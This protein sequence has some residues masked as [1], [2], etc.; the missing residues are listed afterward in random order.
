MVF[1]INIGT[2]EG[3]TYKLESE[4][5]ALVGKELHG[6]IQGKDVS[7]DLEGYEF[8]LT[9]ASD[10]AGFTA[11]AAVEGSGKSKLLLSYEKGMK[12]RPK[13]ENKKK[14]SNRKPKGLRLR[15]TVR[16]KII[17][18]DITQ[19]NLKATKQGTKTLKDIFGP[20]GVSDGEKPAETP[21]KEKKE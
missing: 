19:I 21:A 11:M 8:Q 1:K 17:S 5:Q 15:K 7:P 20:K 12:N 10:K 16:G 18:E 3:K 4:S 9:G 14:R 13:Y 2:K 6:T